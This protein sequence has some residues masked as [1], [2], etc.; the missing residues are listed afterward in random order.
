MGFGWFWNIPLHDG[1]NSVGL[2]TKAELSP[3]ANDREQFYESAIKRGACYT[4]QMLARAARVSN[5]RCIADYSYRP[6]RLVGPGF[7][8]AGDAG[9]FQ[10]TYLVHGHHA[11]HDHRP[12]GGPGQSWS[13]SILGPTSLCSN[14]RGRFSGSSA[15]F[16][17][18]SSISF[19]IQRL[20]NRLL[21]KAY[22]MVA[23][24]TDPKDAFIRLVSGRLGCRPPGTSRGPTQVIARLPGRTL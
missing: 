7:L 5:L 17:G 22:S 13:P 21:W 16:I 2:I 1:T 3:S 8:L 20:P 10:S 23:G 4:R 24:A 9:N 6:R 14:T 15:G 19:T 11:R 18:S 12:L